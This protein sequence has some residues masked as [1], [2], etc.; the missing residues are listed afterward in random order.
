MQKSMQTTCCNTE[1]KR[2][3]TSA[4][5]LQEHLLIERTKD[6]G[7]MPKRFV[8]LGDVCAPIEFV[9]THTPGEGTNAINDH[10]NDVWIST[11][12]VTEQEYYAFFHPEVKTSKNYCTTMMCA[13]W[14]D[15][16]TFC[17]GANKASRL[18]GELATNEVLRLPTCSDYLRITPRMLD[19][20]MQ[21]DYCTTN[22][23]PVEM[24]REWTLDVNVSNTQWKAWLLHSV[25]F[26][27]RKSLD[28]QF[29]QGNCEV[30][31]YTG[32]RLVIASDESANVLSKNIYRKLLD[33]SIHGR[34][35]EHR[36]NPTRVACDDLKKL[37]EDRLKNPWPD[38]IRVIIIENEPEVEVA[39]PSTTPLP[40]PL[41]PVIAQP[42]DDKVNE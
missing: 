7:T 12:N 5:V 20:W 2:F 37:M 38:D 31:Y 36:R 1:G 10:E 39:N 4:G 3:V 13:T 21:F 27:K 9:L 6:D 34:I 41:P 8:K 23:M 16:M 25:N 11:R 26:V 14:I 15:A 18:A 30:G 29:V 32:F 35:M 24:L 17:E 42:V 40:E 33:D 19:E 22:S 28:I